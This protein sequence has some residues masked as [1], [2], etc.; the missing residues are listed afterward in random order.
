MSV[1]SIHLT[2]I[3]QKKINVSI[4]DMSLNIDKLGLGLR[5]YLP[6]T[7]ESTSIAI[8]NQPPIVQSKQ[9]YSVYD[10]I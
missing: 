3:S 10:S 8:Q 6:G 2:V 1:S 5:P 4:F 7:N 9:D